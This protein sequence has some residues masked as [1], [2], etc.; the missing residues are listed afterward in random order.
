MNKFSIDN[1]N[2]VPETLGSASKDIQNK[3]PERA[4]VN[5]KESAPKADR[6]DFS[7]RSAEARELAKLVSSIPDIRSERVN[8]MQDA[9]A[10]QEFNPASRD[11]ASA[12]IKEEG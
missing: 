12:L 8:A 2:K 10:R 5:R 9:I 1:T 7:G 6:V 4:E 3:R 11:I